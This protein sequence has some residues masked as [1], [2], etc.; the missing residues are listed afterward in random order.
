MK[1]ALPVIL[2]SIIL[3]LAARPA[4]AQIIDINQF[5]T[6]V[7]QQTNAAPPSAPNYPNA[8]FFGTYLDADPAY[9]VTNVVVTSPSGVE[10]TLNQYSPAYFENGTPITPT[11]PISTPI[12]RVE[13][14]II[15][16]ITP[17][18]TATPTTP[19]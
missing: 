9:S 18:P 7:Y 2:W 3:V 12:T 5:K 14:T 4:A 19:T 6:T 15:I 11:S 13:P 10:L 17:T 1:N 8:C 16:L